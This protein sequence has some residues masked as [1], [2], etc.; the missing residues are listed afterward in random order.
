MNESTYKIYILD[1]RIIVI[2]Y[3]DS[4]NLEQKSFMTCAGFRLCISFHYVDVLA[5]DDLLA[6]SHQELVGF[7]SLVPFHWGEGS[8]CAG[9]TYNEY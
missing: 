8:Q 2:M 9:T 3:V 5:H 6:H 7:Q 1:S 4:C